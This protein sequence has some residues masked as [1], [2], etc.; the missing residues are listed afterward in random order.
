MPILGT[1]WINARIEDG[2]SG[3]PYNL[4]SEVSVDSDG[5]F[6][7]TIPEEM[8]TTAQQMCE[9]RMDHNVYRLKVNWVVTGKEKAKTRAFVAEIVK[10]HMQ[11]EV[12]RE[13]VIVYRTSSDLCYWRTAKGEI[14]PNAGFDKEG[15]EKG[16]GKFCGSNDATH[17]SETYSVGVGARVYEKIT[18]RRKTGDHVTYKITYGDGGGHFDKDTWLQKLNQFNGLSLSRWHDGDVNDLDQIPYTEEAAKFFYEAM[19]A[20]CKLSNQIERF[21]ESPETVQKAIE[22]RAGLFL[23]KGK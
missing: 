7:Y 15:Y 13:K 17:P 6:R 19:I 5:L 18:A 8:V 12:I 10:A 1:E 2:A 14:F 23:T 4:K 22:S 3:E 9:K 20:L 11:C 21:F 16:T